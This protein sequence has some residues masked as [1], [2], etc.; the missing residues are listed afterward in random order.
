MNEYE[1]TPVLSDAV[2][3][4]ETVPFWSSVNLV[5]ALEDV[6]NKK[7]NKSTVRNLT[8]CSC[9]LDDFFSTSQRT[10]CK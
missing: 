7:I 3:T 5:H 10:E 8:F 2:T 9:F 4:E 1:N 6:M